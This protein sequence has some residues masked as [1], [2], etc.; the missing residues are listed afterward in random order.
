MDQNRASEQRNIFLVA[1][2]YYIIVIYYIILYINIILLLFLLL[3]YPI[4]NPERVKKKTE[5]KSWSEE[6]TCIA[7][8]LIKVFINLGYEIY[9]D[10]FNRTLYDNIGNHLCDC[11]RKF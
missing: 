3:L 7:P 1:V 6:E 10:M 4:L 2:Y 11:E 8:Y 5:P 9:W